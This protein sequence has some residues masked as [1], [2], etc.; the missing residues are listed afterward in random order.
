MAPKS[1]PNP[2]RD[3]HALID[4]AKTTQTLLTHYQSSLTL[5]Q[6]S[7]DSVTPS[8]TSETPPNP[9]D[10]IKATTTLLRSHT[11]T[12]SLLLLTPPLTATAISKK[13]GDVGAGVLSSMIAAALTAPQAGQKDELGTLLR[14]ELR[15]Q[16][17][18]V[19]GTWSDIPALVLRFAERRERDIK[20]G[21]AKDEGP[22]ESDKQNVL[23][24]TG[25]VWEACDD[26]LKICNNGVVGLVV[27]KAE[28]WRGTLKDAVE[29]L[30]EWGEDEEDDDDDEAEGSDN[31]FK[32]EDDIFAAANKLGKG[33]KELKALLDISLKKLKLVGTLYQALIKRRLKVFPKSFPPAN[34]TNGDASEKPL[35][36]MEKLE[37]LM[38]ILKSIPDT[39]DDLASGFYDLDEEEAKETLEKC[40]REAK[41]A[42]ALV[43][44]SWAG[45]DDEFTAWSEKWVSALEAS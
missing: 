34:S 11:T 25:V 23:S 17:K 6:T 24:S 40:C 16:V 26:L 13:L 38:D 5:S 3:L 1:K 7:S 31:E 22:S 19:L 20:I 9:L 29:E 43:K 30:K 21:K 2:D 33:D 8:S 41:S 32:D 10:V 35:D 15:V 45:Q 37:K 44:Q 18:R 36:S 39:V 4:V 27:K 12:L 42:A 14:T 28:E